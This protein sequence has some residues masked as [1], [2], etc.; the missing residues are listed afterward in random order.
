MN[1]NDENEIKKEFQLER[2]IF[3]SDAVFAIIITIMILDVKLPE[4]AQYTS[5]TDAK[6]AFLHLIPKLAGYCVSFYAVGRLWMQ[7]LRIFSFLKDYN[8]QLLVINLLFLFSVSLYPFA[9]SF[10]FNSGKITQYSWGIYTYATI[11]LATV[12]TQTMLMGYLI[13]N[14]ELLCSNTEEIEIMLRWKIARF[15][16]F[17]LPVFVILVAATAYFNLPLKMGLYVVFGPIVL[18]NVVFKILKRIYFRKYKN[19]TVTFLSL[20]TRSKVMP[21]QAPKRPKPK[22]MVK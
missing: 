20:F 21:H 4:V 22:R 8:S 5:E 14:K 17:V 2:L 15:D 16:Y 3:F 13:K 12:F 9:L 10:L 19:D 18:Y 1:T 11:T 7:H 6:N